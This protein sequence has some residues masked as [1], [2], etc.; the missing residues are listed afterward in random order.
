[1][2]VGYYL[3]NPLVS[4]NSSSSEA[5]CRAR[6]P[7]S[8]NTFHCHNYIRYGSS[9]GWLGKSGISLKGPF[10]PLG[11]SLWL[12]YTG[13]KCLISSELN[14]TQGVPIRVLSITL[15]KL[16]WADVSRTRILLG[17]PT[18]HSLTHVLRFL[19]LT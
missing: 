1:M 18:Q 6:P 13:L 16:Y 4:L 10:G 12:D 5:A 14:P 17:V 19:S 8:A 15:T 7:L 2:L 3:D 9:V 11:L